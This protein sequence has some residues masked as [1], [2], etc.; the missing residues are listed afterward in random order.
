MNQAVAFFKLIRW[1]NL[2]FIALTQL[3]F[4]YGLLHPVFEKG[5]TQAVISDGMLVLILMASVFIAAAG[6]IIN[7]YFDINIDRINKPQRVLIPKYVTRRWAILWHSLLSFTGVVL[8]FYAGWKVGVW[9]IGPSNFLCAFLL[10]VYSAAF[11]KRFLSGN[12]II[13]LLT[14]WT[15]AILGLASFYHL[16][17]DAHDSLATQGR[18]LRFTILYASFAFISS[19]IR[20]AVKDMEDLRGDLHYGCKTLPIV[21]GI[22]AAKT[23]VLVWLVV[24]IGLLLVVQVYAA[25]LG[26]WLLV[27][28]GF[29][30]I[31]SPLVYLFFKFVKAR[32]A[33]DY[34][35]ISS[36]V[37]LVMLAGILSLLFFKIYM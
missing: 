8:S 33:R 36:L 29:L 37:K 25:Q 24:L 21:A 3:L 31:S 26:W 13:A 23:Y 16:Y 9:W 5:N 20:E 27:L 6:Y 12:L 18:V 34:H 30:F 11:K 17:Y 15:V 2:L 22:N 10:F 14:A 7:D 28:Y 35:Y 1:P 32:H 4:Q 19:L